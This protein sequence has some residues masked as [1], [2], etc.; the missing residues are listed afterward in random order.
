MH[1]SNPYLDLIPAGHMVNSAQRRAD[2]L[3][4]RRGRGAV[5]TFI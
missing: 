1:G 3:H 2:R 5:E 4:A